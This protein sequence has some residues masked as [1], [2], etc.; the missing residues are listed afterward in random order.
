MGGSAAGGRAGVSRTI[1]VLC[2][3]IGLLRLLTETP[4]MT[5]P[6]A[7]VGR[8]CREWPSMARMLGVGL[9]WQNLAE[10]RGA[11][12]VA[13]G[14]L[15]KNWLWCRPVW[16]SPE[17]DGAL[18]FGWPSP[19]LL[20]LVEQPGYDGMGWS[21]GLRSEISRWH[22]HCAVPCGCSTNAVHVVLTLFRMNKA[23]K[24]NNRLQA[25]RR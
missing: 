21:C 8:T 5:G 6:E 18:R 2:L 4:H 16:A 17:P 24:S 23:C 1:P 11:D 25:G 7:A 14:R 22:G 13:E 19:R 15:L 10:L 3:R 20:V 9:E 12:L